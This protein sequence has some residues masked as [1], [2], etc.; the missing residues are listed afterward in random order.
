MKRALM[1]GS[2]GFIGRNLI[3]KLNQD[4]DIIGVDPLNSYSDHHDCFRGTFESWLSNKGYY[5]PKGFFDVIIHL[6]AN[7]IDVDARSKAGVSIY[8]DISLDLAVCKFVERHHP[9]EAFIAMSSCAVDYPADPYAW[10]KLSLEKFCEKLYRK[11]IPVKIL[12][13]FSGYGPDQSMVYPFRAILERALNY[14]NPLTVWGGK[15][16]RDFIHIDDL[17]S[18]IMFAIRHFPWGVPIEI[19]TAL[20][21]DMVTLAKMIASEVGYDPEIYCDESKA[22]ASTFR[23]AK[24]AEAYGWIPTISLSEGIRR[25]VNVCTSRTLISSR[26]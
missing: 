6:G 7:I 16:V 18:A 3:Q 12:R 4:Y 20:G 26:G 8:D 2:A 24:Q 17:T 10:I 19:G 15:Q 22:T 9:R 21:T 11:G 14:E 1:I 23:V 13:P 5:Y 25:A